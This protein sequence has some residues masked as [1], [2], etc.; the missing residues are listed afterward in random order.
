[1]NLAFPIVLVIDITK[2]P[3]VDDSDVSQAFH[4]L[5]GYGFSGHNVSNEKNMSVNSDDRKSSIGRQLAAI[6][7]YRKEL[8]SDNDIIK[9]NAAIFPNSD[10]LLKL[11]ENDIKEIERIFS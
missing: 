9:L 4:D 2:S 3:D 6:I 11:N 1:M 7:L 8:S 5:N 10:A